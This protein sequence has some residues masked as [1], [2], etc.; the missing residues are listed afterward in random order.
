MNRFWATAL[1]LGALVGA[2]VGPVAVLEASTV[3]GTAVQITAL[4]DLSAT[5]DSQSRKGVGKIIAMGLGVAGLGGLVSG[6]HMTGAIGV[7]SALGMGFLPGVVSSAFDTHSAPF[8]GV[9]KQF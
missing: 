4:D 7:G 3:Q 5:V 2:S 1:V 6:Y 9:L 8:S